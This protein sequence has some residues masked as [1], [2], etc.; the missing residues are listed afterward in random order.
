MGIFWQRAIVPR[1][2]VTVVTV[3]AAKHMFSPASL[4]GSPGRPHAPQNE[5]P[6]WGQQFYSTALYRTELT[7]GLDILFIY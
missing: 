6:R 2:V 4:I 7:A 3:R 5:T 1:T